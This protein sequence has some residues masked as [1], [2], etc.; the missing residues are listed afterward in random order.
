MAGESK[1]DR[2]GRASREAVITQRAKLIWFTGL[3]SAGK[4]TL[5]IH[6]ERALHK[7]NFK[8][9]LLDGDDLRRGLNRDLGFSDQHRSENIRRA[10]EVASL[11]LD[12]GVIVLA[13]FISPF[14]ADRENVRDLVG[15]ENFIE[16]FVD[17]PLAVCE[18]RDVKGLYKRARNGEIKQLTG[19]DSVYEVPLHPHVRLPTA[20][21]SIESCVDQLIK[22]VLPKITF[23]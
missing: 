1:D 6:L 15:K 13:S 9:Y 17:C 18:Q 19:I 16:V 5:A 21:S 7:L 20:S 3:P 23:R 11:L 12:A 14:K 22:Y 10:G 8:T 2:L 4:T